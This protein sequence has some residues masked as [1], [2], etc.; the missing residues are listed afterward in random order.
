MP[1]CVFN[2]DVI[3]ARLSKFG[4]VFCRSSSKLMQHEI[5][6]SLTLNFEIFC[7]IFERTCETGPRY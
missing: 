3:F 1:V 7:E 2:Y 5:D 4:Q 6:Y